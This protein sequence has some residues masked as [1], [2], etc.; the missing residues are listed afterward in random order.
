MPVRA[1]ERGASALKL[2]GGSGGTPGRVRDALAKARQQGGKIKKNEP[3]DRPKQTLLRSPS[4]T[5]YGSPRRGINRGAALSLS[6]KGIPS[7]K[8]AD[9]VARVSGG[10]S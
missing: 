10:W 8:F 5:M 4:R 6:H 7:R 1:R 3:E 9:K 2:T